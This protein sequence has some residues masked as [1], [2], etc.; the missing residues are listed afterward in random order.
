MAVSSFPSSHAATVR[1]W[2]LPLLL[3]ASVALQTTWLAHL[4]VGGAHLDLPLLTVVCVGLLL[5]WEAGASYG[6]AVGLVCGY[7]NGL[8]VGAW[9]FARAVAGGICGLFEA[10]LSRDNPF[11]PPVCTVGAVLIGNVL[12]YLMSPDEFAGY[13]FAQ[14]ALRT[15]ISM[16]LNALLVWPV[17]MVVEK[18]LLP[19]R[20]LMFGPR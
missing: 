16:G 4:E 9:G 6:L 7:C 10:R 19:P 3:L 15:L 13:T 17:Y 11:A 20:R 14:I 2:C 18:I 12:F 8:S 5:G 1:W